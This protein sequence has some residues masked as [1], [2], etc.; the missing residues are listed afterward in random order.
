M[1][2]KL[3]LYG[4]IVTFASANDRKGGAIASDLHE[5]I[6]SAEDDKYDG[7]MDGIEAMILGH[8]IAG[9]DITTPAYL[10]GIQSAVEGCANNI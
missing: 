3:P 2:I 8:A 1:T 9:I 10:E 5:P 6:A 7:A 4:I